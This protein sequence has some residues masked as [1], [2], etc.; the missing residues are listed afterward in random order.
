MSFHPAN[1]RRRTLI[2]G[3]S[4][5]IGRYV[6]R[7]LARRGDV[8]RIGVRDPERAKFLL[9]MGNVGQI[10]VFR[11]DGRDP[12]RV[13]DVMQGCDAVVNLIGILRQTRRHRFDD[14]HHRA[15]THI[16]AA[17]DK[18]GVKKLVH[19]SAITAGAKAKSDYARSKA[20]GEGGVQRA[21]QKA[22]IL[23]PGIIVGQED[24]FLNRFATMA[25][26]SPIL[27]VI[28]ASFADFWRHR[29]IRPIASRARGIALQPVYVDDVAAAVEAALN[30][31]FQGCFELVGPE[32]YHFRALLRQILH[33]QRRRRLLL[34]MPLFLVRAMAFLT[35]WIPM[36]PITYG[37]ALMLG[38]RLT[39]SKSKNMHGFA[40]LGIKPRSLVSSC[41]WLE[42]KPAIH[43][44]SHPSPP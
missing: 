31:S 36:A 38:A 4:G 29:A 3:G 28:G 11:A 32:I 2:F 41:R 42:E 37:E 9:P 20:K 21:F 23:R 27:P 5:F 8:L 12:K 6:V 34:P 16:A 26:F 13:L 1:R 43:P 10:T 14:Y 19:I 24:Q 22:V 7:R 15:A 39:Q 40:A 25:K 17:A 44:A 18:V 35:G 33:W 30:G